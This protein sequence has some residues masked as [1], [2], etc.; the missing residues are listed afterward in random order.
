MRLSMNALYAND[1]VELILETDPTER[2]RVVSNTHNAQ[3]WLRL[4]SDWSATLASSTVL[5]LVDF[6]NRRRGEINDPEK[7][8]AAAQ[9]DRDISQVSLSQDWVWSLSSRHRTQ[10]GI[11]V[12]YSEADFSYA[13]TAEY[14]GLQALY[15]NQSSSIDRSVVAHPEGGSYAMYVSDRWKLSDR[16]VVEWG[17][18]WDDQT[19]TNFGSDSQLSPRFNWLYKTSENTELRLAP[20]DI[21]SPSLS[22]RCRLKM[23]L[24][25]TGQPSVETTLSQVFATLRRMTRR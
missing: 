8:I 5:A 12:T 21:T 1:M 4:D 3:V 17:L 2:E 13:G 15:E 18:R 9:D 10:W 7:M 14:S 22:S 19:Y 11:N 16:A 24:A 6:A 23:D 20:G 25:T